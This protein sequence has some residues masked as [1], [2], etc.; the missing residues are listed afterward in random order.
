MKKSGLII[1]VAILLL[2]ACSSKESEQNS[3][4]DQSWEEI[5]QAGEGTKVRMFMWGG[6]DGINS[7]MDDWVAPRLRELY[8][9][10]FE[11]VPVDT[12][13]I[14]QKLRTEKEAGKNEGTIDIIWLNGE[15]FK[16]AKKSE[17]LSKPFVQK[18]PNFNDFYD[19]DNVSFQYDFGTE[20]NDLEAPWGKVQ[21]VFFYDEEKI[22]TPPA[23]FTELVAWIKDNPGKFTYPEASDFSGNAFLRHVLYASAGGYEELL[24][25]G[26][27][28]ELAA[29]KSEEMWDTLREIKPFLWREGQTY[30]NSLTELDRLFSQEEVWMTMGYNEA[31]AE[32]M[33][34]DRIFPETTKSFVLEDVGSI[35]NTHFLAIPFNSGNQAGAMVAIDFLLSPEAQLMKLGGEYWGEST[36]ISLEKLSSQDKNEF[37]AINRGNSVLSK[38]VLDQS[39]VPEIDAAYVEWV[40]EK[41]LDEVV[42]RQ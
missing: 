22:Q 23:T 28:E 17:L 25:N 42:E 6:D 37:D 39:L 11:R 13:E 5:V 7:Y 38:E 27:S 9:I 8:S 19:S 3:V 30:P 31:R 12:G 34:K 21:Y 1:L 4:V 15:N 20:T 14:L 2:A 10:D 26:F 16:N 24:E 18:L 35:G 32:H 29:E 40:K 41:W 33:I 36:P